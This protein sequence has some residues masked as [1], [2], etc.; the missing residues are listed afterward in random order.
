M[1]EMLLH[2]RL[3]KN[4]LD[5][6]QRC[7]EHPFISGLGDGTLPVSAFRRYV[8]QDAYFLRAFLSAYALCTARSPDI[9]AAAVL[10]EMQ[11][12]SVH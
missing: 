12:I 7:L 1:M 3:W 8:A 9:E 4:N 5:L 11:R 6:A 2:E 10:V